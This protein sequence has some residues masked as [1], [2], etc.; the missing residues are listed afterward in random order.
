[1]CAP[2]FKA[3]AISYVCLLCCIPNPL[4]PSSPSHHHTHAHTTATT[5]S[6]APT[7]CY[8][9]HSRCTVL[10]LPPSSP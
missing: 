8:L 4:A 7:C 10:P 2:P 5:T 1:M 6:C 9:L 3:M